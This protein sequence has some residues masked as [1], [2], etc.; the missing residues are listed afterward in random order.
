MSSKSEVRRAINN[1]GIKIN[2][3]LVNDEN[4]IIN[5]QIFNEENMKISF[6]KKN[7][8]YSKLFRS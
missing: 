3:L 7:I 1:N 2:D 4:K 8:F 6:G 5:Y